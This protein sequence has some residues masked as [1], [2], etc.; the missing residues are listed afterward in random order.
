M[1]IVEGREVDK[2]AAIGDDCQLSC[3]PQMGL[4]FI[5]VR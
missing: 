3:M 4:Q 1:E 5:E 2:R